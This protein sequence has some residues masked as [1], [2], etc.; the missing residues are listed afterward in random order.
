M[1]GRNILEIFTTYKIFMI[2][3]SSG[4]KTIGLQ[5]MNIQLENRN[6]QEARM[7]HLFEE[8][9]S[10]VWR[11]PITCLEKT[12]HLWTRTEPSGGRRWITWMKCLGLTDPL[13]EVNQKCFVCFRAL[14]VPLLLSVVQ[15]SSCWVWEICE[16][17]YKKRDER[18]VDNIKRFEPQ[19]AI[20]HKV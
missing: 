1:L 18:A 7:N 5:K 11:K 16:Q 13:V 14:N 19:P 15:A 8:N 6:H 2:T 10:P 20:R 4:C 9:E 12:N 17:T 3:K